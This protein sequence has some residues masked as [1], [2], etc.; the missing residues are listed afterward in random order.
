MKWESYR[1]ITINKSKSQNTKTIQRITLNTWMTFKEVFLHEESNIFVLLEME[2]WNSS[3][4]FSINSFVEFHNALI[5]IFRSCF[6][7][8]MASFSND[9]RHYSSFSPSMISLWNWSHWTMNFSPFKT[10]ILF[11]CQLPT[12]LNHQVYEKCAWFWILCTKI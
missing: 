8:S 6:S 4:I 3:K 7:C 10:Y 9:S 1:D 11:Y 2:S 12:C 5:F